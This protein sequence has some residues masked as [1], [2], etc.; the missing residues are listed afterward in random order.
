MAS[1]FATRADEPVASGDHLDVA[2]LPARFRKP[3]GNARD[4]DLRKVASRRE[5]VQAHA[6]AHLAAEPQHRR[7]D[8][9]QRYRY[10]RQAGGPGR[11]IGRHEREIVGVAV[12]VERCLALPCVPDRAHGPD[13]VAHARRRR[14]PG[15]AIAALVVGFHLRAEPQVEAPLRC[16]VKVPG[17]VG[18]D[19]G[20][21]RK[22]HRHGCAELD[23]LGGQGGRSKRKKGIMSVLGSYDGIEAG[24]LCDAGN[25]LRLDEI[26]VRDLSD[27]AHA[28]GPPDDR[29]LVAPPTACQLRRGPASG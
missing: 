7:T 26:V 20:R 21:A 16:L 17:H 8:R 23:A 28:L 2:P 15:K 24:A 9:R 13:I 25:L 1:S 3:F 14:R 6:V 18:R 4:R 5:R 22:G 10:P 29:S 11:E 27:D 19:R 12:V